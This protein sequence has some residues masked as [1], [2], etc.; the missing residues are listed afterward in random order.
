VHRNSFFKPD[1]FQFFRC[2]RKTAL[3]HSQAFRGL[4]SLRRAARR[5]RR[6]VESTK[7]LRS[8]EGRM[9]DER[10]VIER[11]RRWIESMVV[12]LELCPFA[13]RV[14]EGGTIRYVVSPAVDATA[15]LDDLGR[16]LTALAESPSAARATTL[17]IH[18][19]VLRN[20]LDYNDFLDSADEAIR[21][22]GL[23]GVVQIASFHPDYQ[24]ADAEPEAV[25]NYTNRSPYPML[26]LLR[27]ESITNAGLAEAE[28][29]AIPQRN[30][31]RLRALGI[32]AV[33]ERLR[34]AKADAPDTPNDH[35]AGR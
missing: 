16:E 7:M 19:G 28:L 32:E 5:R 1:F 27:E 13:R 15:L 17:L 4:P 20:F 34:R 6:G 23:A 12:G 14:F 25:E 29:L 33:R 31:A 18:P 30:V 24:F 35:E 2:L 26:H 9:M 11:T 21:R 10:E 3:I 8:N 22:L